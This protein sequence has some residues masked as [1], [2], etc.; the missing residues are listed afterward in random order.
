MKDTALHQDVLAAIDRY[1]DLMFDSDVS[2]FDRV[3]AP[4]AQ[5]HGFRGQEL[6]VLTAA[7]Y[8]RVL[9]TTPSPEAKA[10]PRQQEVLL[11]DLAA[12][13]QALAKVRVRVDQTLYVDYLCLHL[14]DGEWLVTA[15]SFHVE[16]QFAGA[17]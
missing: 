9:E 3:F 8:R 15:K 13:S 6:R 2:R 5:L 16:R 1:F 17:D 4:T 10:A 7:A 14:I 11:I 12:P